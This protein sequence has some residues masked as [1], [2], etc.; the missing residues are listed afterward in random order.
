MDVVKIVIADDHRLFRLGLRQV[1]TKHG[2]VEVVAE[3]ATGLEA[4]NAAREHAP[5]IVLM[6]ISMPELNGIEAA[7]RISTECP[8]TRVIILSMHADHRYV[9]EALKAGA[10]AYLLKDSA[11]LEVFTAIRRVLEGQRYVSSQIREKNAGY[12]DVIPA[13]ED[14]AFRALSAR[15]REVLQLIAEGLS[16]RQIADK[17]NVSPK[18]VETHRGHIM[19]K[20][21]IHTIAELTKYA[22]RE[23][24]TSMD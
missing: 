20:L 19:E 12:L 7:R 18:T 23:G 8:Q 13:A 6:D 21:D 2:D 1:I 3:A 14:S 9:V 16:T 22:L 10:K 5:D 17:L 15:E 4:V 11:P 24:L